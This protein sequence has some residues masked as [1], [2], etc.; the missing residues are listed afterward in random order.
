MTCKRLKKLGIL[1]CF[2]L[3]ALALEICPLCYAAK[4]H[5]K[6]GQHTGDSHLACVE[7]GD[8]LCPGPSLGGHFA[9]APL[10]ALSRCKDLG[11]SLSHA[12][13]HR[14]EPCLLWLNAVL[15]R[16]VPCEVQ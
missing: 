2:S 11:F 9:V 16:V 6:G 4:K 14:I 5:F 12:C 3:Y 1:C 10:L 13:K 8:G 15:A 7:G